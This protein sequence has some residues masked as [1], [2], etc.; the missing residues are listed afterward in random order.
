MNTQLRNP[1]KLAFQA[2]WHEAHGNLC[3]GFRAAAP[4]A[5][6]RKVQT[7]RPRVEGHREHQRG[8]GS[9]CWAKL[10]RSSR[11][12]TTAPTCWPSW[13][14]CPQSPQRDARHVSDDYYGHHFHAKYDSVRTR[15]R[16]PAER[17]GALAVR[18]QCQGQL[19][20]FS[21]GPAPVIVIMDIGAYVAA[22]QRERAAVLPCEPPNEEPGYP[23]R[24]GHQGVCR[25]Q[26]P[27]DT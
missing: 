20:L 19:S 12:T 6:K 5:R 4:A 17:T 24:P 10:G 21:E 13:P 18:R 26:V 2:R 22:A 1:G 15:S 9:R 7:L 8:Y 3:P 25:T 27:P 16:I 14:G 23:T 11:P